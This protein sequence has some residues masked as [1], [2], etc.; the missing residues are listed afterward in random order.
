MAEKAFGAI[1]LGGTKTFVMIAK[2]K[3][4][5]YS[6]K[7]FPTLSPN[8]TISDI[9]NFFK[10]E[11]NSLD[12]ELASIGIGS[13]GPLDLDPES[14]TFGYITST[15]K[16]GW[17]FT[18][19][20]GKI[21]ESLQIP[22]AIDTDVNA[23][24]LGEFRSLLKQDIDSFVYIT[25]GTGIGGGFIINRELVH[26]LVHPEF[27]HIRIP[28][29]KRM[30]PFPGICPYHRDCF[31]GLASGP[32][33]EERWHMTAE[34]LPKEH[35]AWELEAD[36]ISLALMNLI[37]TVSPQKIILGG[38]VMHQLHLFKKIYQK[39]Q[40]YLNNYIK[41]KYL[42]EQIRDLIMPPKLKDNSGIF[43]ALHLA[44]DTNK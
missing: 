30:D 7:I 12:L 11:T 18:N 29:N 15:P 20:K 26:G 35:M 3:T 23:S 5:I 13:F 37:C 27:G 41:S 38:G 44:I 40:R 10:D 2:D 32:A 25:I 42:D 43:G 39:T 36:Y 1:E 24:A 6:R 14:K 17:Q 16:E 34:M 4:N 9:T 8:Q 22:A 31:E 19:L 21:E 33:L 28:H